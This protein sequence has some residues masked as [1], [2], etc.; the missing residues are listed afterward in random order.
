M[1]MLTNNSTYV[2]ACNLETY[3]NNKCNLRSLCAFFFD[4]LHEIALKTSKFSPPAGSKISFQ[5]LFSHGFRL[6]NFAAKREIHTRTQNR[7]CYEW[8]TRF[9]PCNAVPKRRGASLWI[10]YTPRHFSRWNAEYSIWCGAHRCCCHAYS[11]IYIV[12]SAADTQ[13]IHVHKS[14]EHRGIYLVYAA[15]QLRF[16]S[17]IWDWDDYKGRTEWIYY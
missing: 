7:S 1:M 10:A 15:M 9:T 11:T 4:F 16:Y 2:H 6:Y 17:W 8:K 5:Q 13:H 14:S 12:L 3:E